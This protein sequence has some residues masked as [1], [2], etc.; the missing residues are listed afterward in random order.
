MDLAFFIPRVAPS[1]ALFILA[2]KA[3]E[4]ATGHDGQG[5]QNRTTSAKRPFTPFE[6]ATLGSAAR[7]IGRQVAL[8]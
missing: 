5:G 8:S 4:P 3:T 1:L 2:R 6:P 7:D